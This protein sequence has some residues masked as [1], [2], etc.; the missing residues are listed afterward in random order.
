MMQKRDSNHG[1]VPTLAPLFG[2][3]DKKPRLLDKDVMA[4]GRA[5]G[6]DIT[7][8]ANEVSAIHCI[9]YRAAAGFRIRDCGSRTGTRLNGNAVRNSHLTDGDVLQIGPFSFEVKIP[10]ALAA[11]PAVDPQQLERVQHS[12]RNIVRLALQLRRKLRHTPGANGLGEKAADLKAKIRSYDQRF[13]QLEQS[14]QELV[15]ERSQLDKDKETHSQHVQQVE[16][17][18]AGRLQETDQEIHQRW[19]EFQKRCAAEEARLSTLPSATTVQNSSAA[20]TFEDLQ[21]E[22]AERERRLKD[23]EDA[24]ARQERD[25]QEDYEELE[26][27]RQQVNQLKSKGDAEQVRQQAELL[28]Q[29][30]AVDQ[31][32]AALRDQKAELTRMFNDLK[33][34]QEELRKQPRGDQKALQ[35]ENQQL[36]QTVGQLEQRIAEAGDVKQVREQLTAQEKIRAALTEEL[37][38]VRERLARVEQAART[39]LPSTE[40]TALRA[41]N[42]E[43]RQLLQR[44][45]F[46]PSSAGDDELRAENKQLRQLLTEYEQRLAA[47]EAAPP[48]DAQQLRD[49]NQLLRQL[50]QEKDKFLEEIR[51]MPPQDRLPLEVCAQTEAQDTELQ[52]LRDEVA[53]LEKQL[54]EERE[55]QQPPLLASPSLDN[56]DLDSVEAEVNRERRQIQTERAKLNKEIEALRARNAE[57]DEA[58]RDL[59]MELSRERA[60]MARERMRLERMREEIKSEM[61]RLQRDGGVRESLASVQRLR[62]EMKTA[63]TRR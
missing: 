10:A 25:A 63:G 15:D 4:V 37:S 47:D 56:I 46:K 27:E 49:E 8:D 16:T 44:Q 23:R 30:A 40:L 6:C 17:D 53:K 59:E 45:L 31:A 26:R 52:R 32:E 42:D 12:R 57:L 19:G 24:W 13:S 7:L 29:K 22:L 1:P 18:I 21:R 39:A 35:Q 20:A 11:T 58:T 60:E 28:R 34:L 43:L 50:L 54:G 41:E 36:R 14:E 51:Q 3:P 5:R 48:A 33:H 38:I 61:E 9:F 62:D 2:G 55:Q